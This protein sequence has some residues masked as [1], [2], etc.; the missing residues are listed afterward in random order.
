MTRRELL[1]L[2]CVASLM[3]AM[4]GSAHAEE[5]SSLEGLWIMDSA[6]EIH[7]DGTRTTNYGEHPRGLFFV[8]HAGR[9][10]MQVYKVGGRAPFASGDRARGTPEEYRA[11]FVSISTH[12]GQVTIDQARRQLIFN[13]EAASFPN[14]EG[15]RQVRDFTYEHGLLSYSVPAYGGSTTAYSTWRR[16]P[17]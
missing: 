10:S 2:G 14:W 8:D 1:S 15:Q 12:I 3:A 6:Y 7:A 4:G 11:A 17:N 16:A 5:L 9:Y 13:I